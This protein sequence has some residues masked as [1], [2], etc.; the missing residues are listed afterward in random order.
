MNVPTRIVKEM[1]RIPLLCLTI[2]WGQTSA[3]ST[4]VRADAGLTGIFSRYS[5]ANFD[6]EGTNVDRRMALAIRPKLDSREFLAEAS[7]LG[8]AKVAERDEPKMFHRAIDGR[9]T[10]QLYGNRLL[11]GAGKDI[12]DQVLWGCAASVASRLRREQRIREDLQVPGNSVTTDLRSVGVERGDENERVGLLLTD[13][14]EVGDYKRSQ[15]DATLVWSHNG[16]SRFGW[17][18]QGG[19][20][21]EGIRDETYQN[22]RGQLGVQYKVTPA[23]SLISNG[24]YQKRGKNQR[25]Y[26]GLLQAIYLAT[27]HISMTGELSRIMEKNSPRFPSHSYRGLI[28][29][30]IGR[31]RLE[32]SVGRTLVE[33]GERNGN[34]IISASA[35]DVF[36]RWH[37]VRVRVT[38][39]TEFV[40]VIETSRTVEA[41]YIFN[42]AGLAASGGKSLNFS[43]NYSWTKLNRASNVQSDIRIAEIAA[44]AQF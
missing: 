5:G 34:N 23:L 21:T 32:T 30:S 9:L 10:S 31:R 39:G 20:G 17:T 24:N 25:I 37:T 13:R 41:G 29:H 7:I 4:E 44:K 11:I 3:G 6:C 12:S 14:N 40:A 16:P 38:Q 2:L 36:D 1:P 8:E 26:G 22:L 42:L 43:V 35:E 18:L 27:E 19:T 28:V 33:R 15:G